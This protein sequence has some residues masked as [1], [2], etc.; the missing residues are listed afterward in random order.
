[1]RRW[2]EH[3][4]Q[5]KALRAY[6]DGGQLLEDLAVSIH[7][8]EQTLLVKAFVSLLRHMRESYR[9]NKAYRTVARRVLNGVKRRVFQGLARGTQAR[10]CRKEMVFAAMN[11]WS[12]VT[13]RRF[14]AMWR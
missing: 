9:L 12:E 10:W 7:F 2:R 14:F 13:K 6:N 5:A 1:V 11:N 8:S 4:A 3:T